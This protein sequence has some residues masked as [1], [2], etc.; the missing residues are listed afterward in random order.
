[1]PT[2]PE[3]A[4]INYLKLL[5]AESLRSLQPVVGQ[6]PIKAYRRSI[7]GYFKSLLPSNS[8]TLKLG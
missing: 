8:E 7:K 2:Q 5:L 3:Q 1:M 4:G 6:K